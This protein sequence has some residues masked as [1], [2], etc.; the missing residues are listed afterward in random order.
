MAWPFT[1]RNERAAEVRSTALP[2]PE[3][4]GAAFSVPNTVT[5]DNA[6]TADTV[7]YSCIR[8]ITDTISTCRLE[9]FDQPTG[10]PVPTR[11]P[12]QPPLVVNPA[13]EFDSTTWVA[14]SVISLATNG[15]VFYGV[16]SRDTLGYATQLIVLPPKQ[17]SVTR[18]STTGKLVYKVKG[19]IQAEGA[20]LHVPW[21]VPPGAVRGISPIEANARG[22]SWAQSLTDFSIQVMANGA[23]PTGVLEFPSEIAEADARRIK[24][25]FDQRHAGMKR[26][27]STAY[28][29][30]G[31]KYTALSLS[32][33]ALQLVNTKKFAAETIAMMF[34]VPP[35]KLGLSGV[36]TFAGAGLAEMNRDFLTALRPYMLRIENVLSTQLPPTQ[37]VKFNTT[38]L[39]QLDRKTL[40]ETQ[41]SSVNAGVITVNEARAERGLPP[42]DGGDVLRL[43]SAVFS[44]DGDAEVDAPDADTAETE[45]APVEATGTGGYS[46]ADITARVNAA[47]A[48]VRTGFDPVGALLVCGLDPI[49][50]LDVQPVT[51]RPL[52]QL[53]AETDLLQ[54]QV[55]TDPSDEENAA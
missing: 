39:T 13:G 28:L 15:N 41:N 34:G 20:V 8:L 2:S 19:A 46:T 47:T 29:F 40:E 1:T 52:G 14:S 42:V 53:D 37:S 50:Y 30:G 54:A 16:V 35:H 31:T 48:L 9:A 24:A 18:D 45:E 22:L 33:E 25:S 23:M 26:A 38:D 7:A 55:D 6:L 5:E 43:P 44:P 27:G 12:V 11:M 36:T 10:E 21:L 4:L 51:V 49:D 3:Q 32:P 17:V